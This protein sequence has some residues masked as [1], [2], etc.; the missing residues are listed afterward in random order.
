M[1]KIKA[2]V[3]FEPK[4]IIIDGIIIAEYEDGT[5]YEFKETFAYKWNEFG[6]IID[7]LH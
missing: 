6:E 3:K 5:T 7:L 2:K 1:D 4:Q